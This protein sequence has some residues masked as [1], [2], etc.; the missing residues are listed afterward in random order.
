MLQKFVKTHS[1]FRTGS[2]GTAAAPL[3]IIAAGVRIVGDIITQGEIQIDGHVE[4]D[5]SCATLVVGEGAHVAGEVN[6]EHVRVHGK[7]TGKIDAAQVRIA[8]S[9]HVVGDITHESLEIEAGAYLEGHL[10]RR[11]AVPV[12]AAPPEPKRIEAQ[13]GQVAAA[14]AAAMPPQGGKKKLDH[15]ETGG[16]TT[17]TSPVQG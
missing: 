3:S 6:A 12:V 10:V 1:A 11:P 8:R 16:A 17:A 5:I 9:A 15:Q 13:P 4:G 2:S 14:A 7:L